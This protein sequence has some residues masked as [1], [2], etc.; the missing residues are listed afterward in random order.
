MRICY[1][2]KYFY[3]DYIIL[4]KVKKKIFLDCF[5]KLCIINGNLWL[6]K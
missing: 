5:L 6:Y 1:I 2:L 4:N 3:V